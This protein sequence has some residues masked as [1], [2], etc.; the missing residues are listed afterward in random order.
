MV[1][2]ALLI[3]TAALV[4]G[5]G[6]APATAAPRP[7]LVVQ[8][9]ALHR[10]EMCG[11]SRLAAVAAGGRLVAV[12][13]AN[14]ARG[15]RSAT[16]EVAGCRGGRWARQRQVRLAGAGR[17]W[18]FPL[19]GLAA[20]DYR[21]RAG[22]RGRGA[23]RP[24]FAAP[25]Y[26]RVPR[27]APTSPA[28]AEV[29]DLPVRFAV[30]NVNRSALPCSSDGAA[31]VIGGHVVGPRAV[32]AAGGPASAVTLYL[33]EFSFAEWFWR[34]PRAEYDYAAAQAR[35]GHVSIVVDRLGYGDSSQPPGRDV[36]L[37]SQADMAHQIVERLRR[38]DYQATGGASRAF[39]RVAIAG[40][41]VGG[42][43]AELEAYS[44]RDVDGLLLFGWASGGYSTRVL[45]ESAGQ[46]ARCAQ[47]GE[48]ARPGGPGGYAYFSATPESFRD[49]G[50]ADAEPAVV[51]AALALRQRDPCGDVAT[52]IPAV[53][54]SGARSRDIAI[55]VA[56]VFG[57]ADA[58]F[59][60]NAGRDQAGR[61][62]AS[63]DVTAFFVEKAG[64]AL[65]LQRSAPQVRRDVAGWLR[66]HGF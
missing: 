44:F 42:G 17:R 1:R 55:P 65:T 11:H 16:L 8:G 63:R 18:R 2:S 50:Y 56:L 13:T 24:S 37:G 43:V 45:Q 27:P 54:S 34:F 58:V 9:A 49:L 48:P 64:H 14:R 52:L 66:G 35:A 33:H 59:Q 10:V 28:A 30:R 3:A 62:G 21:L 7:R 29:L 12:A 61:Y 20:G 22:V 47:G 4:V 40:H 51:D 25:R 38:G 39:R 23:R 26:L 60:P 31:Y 57:L 41:S 46:N 6:A 36:C 15:R 19:T 53:V 5:K 32:L